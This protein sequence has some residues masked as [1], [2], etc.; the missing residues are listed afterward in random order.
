MH[1]KT[2]KKACTAY[3]LVYHNFFYLF[4]RTLNERL[5]IPNRYIDTHKLKTNNNQKTKLEQYSR[6]DLE[7]HLSGG[8]LRFYNRVRISCNVATV[9]LIM[10]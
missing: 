5:K 6:H 2:I 7:P 1:N 9:V 4:P 8:N 3:H 10:K